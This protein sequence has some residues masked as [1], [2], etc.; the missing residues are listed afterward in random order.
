M[1][2]GR[3]ILE[4]E[5]SGRLVQAAVQAV[6]RNRRAGEV[7]YQQRVST[8]FTL[9]IPC[10]CGG[11]MVLGYHASLGRVVRW[12]NRRGGLFPVEGQVAGGHLGVWSHEPQWSQRLLADKANQEQI[13]RLLPAQTP[14]QALAI[15]V[16]PDRLIYTCLGTER[17]ISDQFGEWVQAGLSLAVRFEEA[18]RPAT[19]HQ[20]GWMERHP[21]LLAVLLIGGFLVLCIV[22]ALLLVGLAVVIAG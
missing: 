1:S 9:E 14:L 4:G 16:Y 17:G 5:L 15:Q 13:V 21:I 10:N 8:R 22:G 20:P 2:M 12:V 18:P 6:T 3:L 7:R 11:R 19:Q